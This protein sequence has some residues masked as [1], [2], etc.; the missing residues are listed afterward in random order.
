MGNDGYDQLGFF[1]LALLYLTL[2]I[3]CLVAT[4]IMG[5]IGVKKSLMLGSFCD[6]MWIL[7]SIPPALKTQYPDSDSFF[8]TDGFIIFVQLAAAILDGFGD[9]V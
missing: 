5:K 8:F 1:S 6:T 3:G 2:G 7:C 9:A 4:A